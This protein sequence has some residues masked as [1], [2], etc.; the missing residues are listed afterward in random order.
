MSH[1]NRY[2]KS[3]IKNKP[4]YKILLIIVSLALVNYYYVSNTEDQPDVLEFSDISYGLGALACGIMGI[5]ISRKYKGSE[6]FAKTYFALG[7]GFLFLFCGDVIY[8]YYEL[9][10]NEEPY[11]S[12]ADVFFLAFPPLIAYH[13]ISNIRYF[14]KDLDITT[15]IGQITFP[16]SI[17]F[18][19]GF[20][21]FNQIHEFNLEFYTS[22]FYVI[23]SSVILSLSMLGLSVFK[24]SVLS[25]AWLLL[26]IG[27]FGTMI[28]D[29]WYYYLELFD[30]YDKSHAVNTVW[31]LGFMTIFYALYKHRQII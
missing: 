6:I 19:Y 4:D 22:L 21:S 31:L 20:L 16:I 17:V 1:K 13:L 14:I 18:V 27:I 7:L 15:V 3:E 30:L 24:K 29:D 25:S 28:A 10:M 26:T 9:V 2:T 11:P 5:L 8:N 23:S 12:I